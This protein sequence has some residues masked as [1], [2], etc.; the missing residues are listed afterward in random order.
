MRLF[1]YL[2]IVATVVA[3][4]FLANFVLSSCA[5]EQARQRMMP[6]QIVDNASDKTQALK[7]VY[8]RLETTGGKMSVSPGVDLYN[9]EG[10]VASPGRIHITTKADFSGSVVDIDLISIGGKQYMRNSLTRQWDV[11]PVPFAPSNLFAPDTGAASIV[12]SARNL[13]KLDDESVD[14]APSYHLK[15][16]ADSAAVASLIGGTPSGSPVQVEAWIGTGDFVVRQIRL[17]GAMLKDDSPKTVRLLKLSKFNE[18]V[19]IEPPT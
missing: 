17:E 5:A 13:S 15:G 3:V 19:T 11:L 10:D 12:R 4:T 18:P 9:V 7:Y 14:G 1:R 16:T 6:Q 2:I 8:F